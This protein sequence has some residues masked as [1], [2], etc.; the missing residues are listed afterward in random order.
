MLEVAESFVQGVESL[1]I[2]EVGNQDAHSTA[3]RTGREV[4]ASLANIRFS[5]VW[6]RNQSFEQSGKRRCTRSRRQRAN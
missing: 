1:R 4:A 6:K 2:E 5:A 3:T